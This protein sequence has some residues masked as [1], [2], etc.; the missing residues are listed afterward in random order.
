[1]MSRTLRAVTLFAGL[2]AALLLQPRAASADGEASGAGAAAPPAPTAPAPATPAAPAPADPLAALRLRCR[3]EPA[4]F[5]AKV[6]DPVKFGEKV[7]VE[8]V[9]FPS[10]VKSV[11]PAKN[12]IVRAKLFRTE[13]PERAAVI[14]LGG[15]RNDPM[16]PELAARLAAETGIQALHMELPFQGQ[17]TPKGRMTGELTF[18]E[19]LRQNEETFVQAAQDVSRA[20]SWLVAERKVDPARI[21]LMGTSLGGFV[22]GC[23]Y[24]MDDRFA[25]CAMQISGGEVSKVIFSGSWLTRRIRDAL[26]AA[27]ETEETVGARMRGMDPSAWARPARRDGL[28]L[29]A[30]E[31]DEIVPLATVESLAKAYGGAKLVVM[32]DAQ[33]I[34]PQVVKDHFHHVAEHLRSRLIPSR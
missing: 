33:H 17:R 11:D 30:A 31:K 1:M 10:P 18:S 2:A 8:A 14:C 29:V 22:S 13:S 21:G 4:A 26:V 25:A 6:A 20:V 19:D 32:K 28:L 23:L 15:W 16:T 5:E 24:G 12:D 9:S 7:L 3:Y 34:A 27:G